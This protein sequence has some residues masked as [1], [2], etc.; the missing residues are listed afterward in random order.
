[1][2]TSR[3]DLLELSH[4]Y[5]PVGHFEFVVVYAACV[6]LHTPNDPHNHKFAVL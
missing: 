5:L 2:F 1:M 4:G 3:K 6:P